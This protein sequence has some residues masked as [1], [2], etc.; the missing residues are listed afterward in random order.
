MKL[1]HI[2]LLSHITFLMAKFAQSTV[3]VMCT[4]VYVTEFA[5]GVLYMHPIFQL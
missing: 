4:Y 3:Y 5:K 1:K 2:E